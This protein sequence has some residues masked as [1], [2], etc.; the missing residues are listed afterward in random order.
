MG[1]GDYSSGL[2]LSLGWFHGRG[3]F[4]TRSGVV[5]VLEE[6]FGWGNGT[7]VLKGKLWD[8]NGSGAH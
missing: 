4:G 7:K 1:G 2:G 6:V 5:E 8:W 3:E